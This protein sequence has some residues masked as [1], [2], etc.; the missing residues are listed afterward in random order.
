MS[1]K[2]ILSLF[3]KDFNIYRFVC[4]KRGLEHMKEQH[5]YDLPWLTFILEGGPLLIWWRTCQYQHFIPRHVFIRT[6]NKKAFAIQFPI[7]NHWTFPKHVWFP[8]KSINIMFILKICKDHVHQG[9]P[10]KK[11][12][13]PP[14][15]SNRPCAAPRVQCRWAT[16]RGPFSC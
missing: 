3:S 6:S 10:P 2:L 11:S 15:D 13:D 5:T 7:N 9:N 1:P 14:E 12:P 4:N 8:S 16:W